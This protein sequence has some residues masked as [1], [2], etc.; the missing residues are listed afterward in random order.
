MFRVI[1]KD[2]NK[3]I[4]VIETI[5]WRKREKMSANDKNTEKLVNGIE[6]LKVDSENQ[7]AND[8]DGIDEEEGT[9]FSELISFTPLA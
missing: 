6:E 3:S 9:S 5:C 8:Q 4:L 7:S 2:Y 1:I